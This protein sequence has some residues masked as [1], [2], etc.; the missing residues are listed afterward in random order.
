[1][2]FFRLLKTL[3]LITT[4]S[5]VLFFFARCGAKDG[6]LDFTHLVPPKV[7]PEFALPLLDGT[8][9]VRELLKIVGA[10]DQNIL[11]VERDG[12]MKLQ[13]LG[14][15]IKKKASFFFK[16]EE[17]I[18]FSIEKQPFTED[19]ITYTKL[20][21]KALSV[22]N[23]LL[24]GG[25]LN[26]TF[27]S[28]KE[29]KIKVTIPELLDKWGNKYCMTHIIKEGVPFSFEQKLSGY[30]I[31]IKNANKALKIAYSVENGINSNAMIEMEGVFENL[32]YSCAHGYL[33]GRSYTLEQ[34]SNFL[35]VFDNLKNGAINFAS[36]SFSLYMDNSFNMPFNI[37]FD[38]L[39]SINADK[40]EV[41]LNTGEQVSLEEMTIKSFTSTKID[42]NIKNCLKTNPIFL[43]SKIEI[44]TIQ[45]NFKLY[46][47]TMT[48]SLKL[49]TDF[50][51][52]LQ[53]GT[54]K[55]EYFKNQENGLKGKELP[56]KELKLKLVTENEIPMNIGLQIFFMRGKKDT[57][58]RLFPE[59]ENFLIA[60][61]ADQDGN[62]I[63]KSRAELLIPIHG[64]DIE[65]ITAADEILI[66]LR[67]STGDNGKNL[68]KINLKQKVR[69][70]IG[71]IAKL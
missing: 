6:Y 45:D 38:K 4:S 67:M 2:T 47:V 71:A 64:S 15:L 17:L 69:I 43:N 28:N 65:K 11:L 60:A 57:L 34:E 63:A 1:M 41:N 53:F 24:T 8:L 10:D 19:G 51:L 62:S 54:K 49:R 48:D 16:L 39:Y 66:R 9:S 36:P 32:E 7:E 40:E 27:T 46:K 29:V 70:G 55:I 12:Q 35:G 50:N 58:Y 56:L 21:A 44:Q 14:N 42:D 18:P 61:Q 3:I 59:D 25:F 33:I 30:V 52:P 26:Y 13:F 22:Q 20:D 31:G 5:I 68:A 23:A 37:S